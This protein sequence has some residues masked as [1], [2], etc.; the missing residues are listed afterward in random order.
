MTTPK[1]PQNYPDTT[2]KMIEAIIENPHI[3]RIELS[4]MLG[5]SIDG[6]KYPIKILSKDGIL[7]REGS[8]RVGKWIIVEES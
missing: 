8:N 1:L 6:V 3:T 5:I 7:K 4:K 2:R